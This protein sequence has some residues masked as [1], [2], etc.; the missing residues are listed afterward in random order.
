MAQ[1]TLTLRLETPADW[2]AVENLTRLGGSMGVSVSTGDAEGGY[3][4]RFTG[5]A[6]P[7]SA[8]G[9][10]AWMTA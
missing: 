8:A 4:V 5:E 3:F 6:V 10:S 2:R 9:A 7:G 1:A